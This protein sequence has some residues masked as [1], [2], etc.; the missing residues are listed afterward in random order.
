MATITAPIDGRI[1]VVNA[2]VG[3][4][5]TGT[6][7]Q[8]Q[9]TRM[10]LAVSVTEDDILDLAVGQ[11]ATVAISATGDTAIGTVTSVSP[12]ASTSGSSTVVSYT[13]VVTLDEATGTTAATG[14]DAPA[15]ATAAASPA[16]TS[17][18][19]LPGMSAEITI[20]IAEAADALA[21]PAIALSGTSGSYTVRVLNSDGTVEARSVDVGLIASDYAQITGGLAEGEA[22]VTGSSADR[23][24]TS[25]STPP[26]PAAAASAASTAA[27]GSSRRPA[28][29]R[30]SH[31]RDDHRPHRG[32]PD[33]RPRAGPG[34]CARG[35]QPAGRGG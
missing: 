22:V 17:A 6:A 7:I 33:V 3:Q 31:E 16:T 26:R 21:V 14:S 24:S 4:E 9:S 12:V 19:P 32:H 1:T 11:K 25:S 28:A 13:V 27:A 15:V 8:L 20:V 35:R 2:V 10:A 29:S 30:G 18:A 23:T 5:S 34:P